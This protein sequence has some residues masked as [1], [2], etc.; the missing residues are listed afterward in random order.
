MK[1]VAVKSKT[2]P[3]ITKEDLKTVHFRPDEAKKELLLAAIEATGKSK[4]ELMNLLLDELPAVCEKII[5]D[6]REREARF[7]RVFAKPAPDKP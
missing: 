6:Q 1:K 7:S 3:E 4:T 5:S 2:K